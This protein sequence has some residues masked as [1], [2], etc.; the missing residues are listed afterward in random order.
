MKSRSLTLLLV[1]SVLLA[2]LA[3]CGLSP[4]QSAAGIYVGQFTHVMGDPE[5]VRDTSP[6]S[7]ELKADGTG[8]HHR[9]GMDFELRWELEGEKITVTERFIGVE[10]PYNGTLRNRELVLFNGDPANP[11]TVEYVYLKP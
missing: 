5:N 7:L 2:L 3:G 11:W 8:V 1:L 9:D 10:L 4:G 6:F